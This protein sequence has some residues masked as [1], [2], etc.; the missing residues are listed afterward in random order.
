VLRGPHRAAVEQQPLALPRG[1]H[2]L[3]DGSSLQFC[4]DFSRVDADDGG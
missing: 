1:L 4:A 3:S 2:G